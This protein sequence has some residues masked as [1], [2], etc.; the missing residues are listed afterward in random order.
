MEARAAEER[1]NKRTYNP[2]KAYLQKYRALLL[3]Y[4][5]LTAQ[6]R[7]L[8]ARATNT[9][10]RIKPVNVQNGGPRDTIGDTAAAVVDAESLLGDTAREIVEEMRGILQTIETVPDEMQKTILTKRYIS[11]KPW[12]AICSEIGYEKTRVHQLHGWAL[13]SVARALEAR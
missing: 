13:L 5:D 9:A 6:I 12:S 1:G 10:A 7:E 3:R 11:G 4:E 8:E 2:A